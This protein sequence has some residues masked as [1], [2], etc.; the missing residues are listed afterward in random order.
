MRAFIAIDLPREIKDYLAAVEE[1][2]KAAAADVKWVKPANIHLT[3]KFLGEIDEQAKEAVIRVIQ[4]T[5]R[6]K[7]PFSLRL[8][9]AGAFPDI[10]YPRVV[11]IG[12][13]K[14]SDE[15]TEIVRALEEKLEKI[16]IAKETRQFRCHITI[17]RVKSGVNRLKLAEKIEEADR[18]LAGRQLEIPVTKIIL[19]KS[20]LSPNGPTYEA[21]REINLKTA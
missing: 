8:S 16:G 4:D 14:G 7:D 9:C 17:G 19:F 5:A 10:R 20:T 13:D 1:K 12:T 21:V 11:W 6:D 3:L 15:T 18:E 2:L